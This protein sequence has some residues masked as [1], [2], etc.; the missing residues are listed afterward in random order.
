[1]EFIEQVSREDPEFFE[2]LATDIAKKAEK[3]AKD[4]S[5]E[6]YKVRAFTRLNLSRHGILFAAIEPKYHVE[7]LVVKW[8]WK[9]F[10][11]FVIALESKLKRGVFLFGPGFS[12]VIFT[13]APLKEVIEDLESRLP[14]KPL[15]EEVAE[16]SERIW[17]KYYA[18]QY[19]PS[20]KNLKLFLK[21]LPRKYQKWKGLVTEASFGNRRLDEFF[22]PVIDNKKDQHL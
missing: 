14:I 4:V 19:V 9:R 21:F 20:R 13:K 22:Q 15:L 7:D 17:Q 11:Q 16:F 6:A 5:R 18:F 3:L 2:N 10:P 8:F 12:D 1:M